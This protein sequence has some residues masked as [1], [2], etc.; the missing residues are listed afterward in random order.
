MPTHTVYKNGH[1]IGYRYGKPGHGHILHPTMEAAKRQ[2]T[3]IH[4]SEARAH[5][6]HIPKLSD[7][8]VHKK[9]H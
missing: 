4:I 9:K 1:R 8:G 7:R 3:A 2:A 5:G 6:H